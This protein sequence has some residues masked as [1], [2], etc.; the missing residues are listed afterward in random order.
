VS[1]LGSASVVDRLVVVEPTDSEI[2]E[3]SV[4]VPDRFRLVWERHFDAVF[5]F[6]ARRVGRSSAR[7]VTAEVFIRAFERRAAYRPLRETCL[8]WLYG[9]AR[10]VISEE[11]R[12]AGRESGLNVAAGGWSEASFEEDADNRV[13]ASSVVRELQE[14]LAGLSDHDRETLLLFSLEG[15]TYAEIANVLEI[16]VGT[17]ASRINRVRRLIREHIPDMEHKTG[18]MIKRG[19]QRE[20]RG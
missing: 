6:A 8:P 12:K 5:R 15:L 17:V 1:P 3:E 14:A 18:V 11:L 9:I 13:V 19:K 10:N 16:P 7:D 20:D 2:L 4:A